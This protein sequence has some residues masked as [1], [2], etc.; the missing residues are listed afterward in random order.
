MNINFTQGIIIYPYSGTSQLF[1]SASAGYVSLGTTAGRVDVAFAF[2]EQNY[3]LT[4]ASSVPN[5]WGPYT[6]GVDTWLYWDINT[7]TAV[8]TFGTTILPPLYGPTFPVSPAE[9]QHFFHTTEKIMYVYQSGGW[10]EAIRVFAAMVN[11]ST[12]TPLGVGFPATPFAGT[13][14][15]ITG[16]NVVGRIIVDNTGTP[17]RKSDGSFFTSEDEF[18]INGS[19]ANTLRF[20]ANVINATAQE[21]IATYQV[22]AYTGFN[23]INLATYN[24]LQTTAIA[25]S[26][27]GLG[28]GQVG[29]IVTQGTVVNP[30]WNWTVAG[31]PLWVDDS[32][33]LTAIDLHTTDVVGHPIAKPPIGRVLSPTS[34]FFDQGL[35][36]AGPAGPIGP[37]GTPALA[38][39]TV[40]GITK[41]SLPATSAINPIAVGDNDPRM[42]DARA[43]L[44]H[45]QP[46][47]TITFTPYGTLTGP[48][49][50]NA[51]QQL[52]DEKLSLDGGTLTG[53]LTLAAN[54]VNPLHAATK[55]YVDSLTLASLTDVTLLGPASLGDVLSYDGAVWTNTIPSFIPKTFLQLTDAPSSYVGQ[56]GLFARVN[57]GETG[58]EFAASA[59]TPAGANTEIQYNNSGSFGADSSFTYDLTSGAFRVS[60]GTV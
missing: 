11:T 19:P 50:Q 40:F 6:N 5:A 56:A 23:E 1:L 22:V 27:Q 49:T 60:P 15:G 43:P 4:E 59:G 33:E 3:L 58:L 37:D 45:E 26:V 20:E 10:R 42:V 13:Q 32:G 17:I 7:Q 41:L 16:S 46:A 25:M 9:D 48:Y 31:A 38:T 55:L 53:F 2:G 36:G 30:A 52:E 44:T 28:I 18:F 29:T 51:I 57:I 24:Q 35:G 21:N 12:F 54:P 47:T 34:V 8:R 39:D 14:V